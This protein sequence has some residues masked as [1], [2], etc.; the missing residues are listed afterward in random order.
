[1]VPHTFEGSCMNRIKTLFFILLFSGNIF[2]QDDSNDEAM[3]MDLMMLLNTPVTTASNTEEKLSDAPA[4]MIVITKKDIKDRGYLQ[5]S[6]IYD[7]LP[8]MEISRGY[9]DNDYKNYWRGYRNTTGSAYL[10]MID[11]VIENSLYW[12]TNDHSSA[13]SMKQIKQIEIV[14][15]PASS[16]YGPNAFMG[17]VNIITENDKSEDGTFITSNVT[18]SDGGE[19]LD[20][21]IFYKNGDFRINASFHIENGQL[22][23]RLDN[24]K[25]YWTQD[26]FYADERLWGDFTNN[27]SIN[28]GKF[29]SHIRNRGIDLGAFFGKSEF[30]VRSLTINTGYGLSYPGDKLLSQGPWIRS[31]NTAYFRHAD[32]INEKVS[33]KTLF[34][35]RSDNLG[36]GSLDVEAWNTSAPNDLVF[37]NG[38][39]VLQGESVRS[40]QF[41]Y[42][43]SSNHAWS[44]FQDFDIKF[45]DQFSLVTGIKYEYK[46]LQKAYGTSVAGNLIPGEFT[47]GDDSFPAQNSDV[48]IYSNRVVWADNGIY[49]Q[50]KFNFNDEQTL[51]LGLRVDDNSFY[52]SGTTIRAGYVH[53]VNENLIAKLLYGEAFQEPVPRNL[54]GGWGGSG[55]EPTLK[56]EETNTIEASFTYT[57][58]NMSHLL[59]VYNVSNKETVIGFAGGAKNAG[60]RNV[61]GVDYHFKS[62][63]QLDGIKSLTL[64][65]YYTYLMTFEEDTY[66]SNTE[67]KTGTINIGDLAEHKIYFGATAQIST[68]FS[69]TLRARYIGER[70]TIESNPYDMDSYMTVDLNLV[71]DNLLFDGLGA[72]LKVTNLL[73]EEYY[74]PGMRS[75]DSGDPNTDSTLDKGTWTGNAWSGSNGWYNSKLIQP[76][77]MFLFSLNLDM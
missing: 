1:M 33:S 43:Q 69:S 68:D 23:N 11:G 57:K 47:V 66:D 12:G 71:Y 39:S 72:S 64:W 51:H 48:P 26:K 37:A 59:S 6:E 30:V 29:S 22:E 58:D 55:S 45:S 17:V 63:F 4:T 14:Y 56:P 60:E 19:F 34:R 20:G 15:G 9:G 2:S 44:F 75:A 7:D 70:K 18:N 61:L 10:L 52:G 62:V 41:T 54:Y 5:F 38:D 28:N 8:G 42:W 53:H 25:F 50:G 13:V 32:K 49:A 46:D 21:S 76:H 65:G 77:R 74:H 16:V 73:D 3:L 24:N 31:S 36:D 35:F 67:E 27:T 40:N